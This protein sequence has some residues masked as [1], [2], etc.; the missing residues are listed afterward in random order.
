MPEA[1]KKMVAMD[2]KTL[3]QIEDDE[4]FAHLELDIEQ[5]K[6]LRVV[7]DEDTPIKM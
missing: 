3:R 7:V 4:M 1:L 2:P 6:T 5:I